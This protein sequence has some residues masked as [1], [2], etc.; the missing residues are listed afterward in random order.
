M[1]SRKV[2]EL[3]RAENE[4]KRRMKIRLSIESSIECLR[5]EELLAVSTQAR[6]A[7]RLASDQVPKWSESESPNLELTVAT[8]NHIVITH[9]QM[10]VS[11]Q[12]HQVSFGDCLE[13]WFIL[14]S[15][16]VATVPKQ[17]PNPEG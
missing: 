10:R 6:L 16:H 2:I 9:M 14:R 3:H 12:S 17:V 8:C 11:H 13:T 4:T 5:P 1:L 7:A 15:R